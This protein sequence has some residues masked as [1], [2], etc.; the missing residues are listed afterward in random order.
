MLNGPLKVGHCNACQSD[1]P[2]PYE[3]W[4]N[5]FKDILEDIVTELKKG[6]GR[7][8]TIFG[9]F[10]TRLLYY[11]LPPRCS[12]CKK[13]LKIDFKK[14]TKPDEIKCHSCGEKIK[15]A[16]A[17]NWLQKKFPAA[18]SF[19]NAMLSEE[20]R[21]E[22]T[23]TE[24][25]ALTCTRCGGSLIVNGEDRIT[26]CEYCGIH[27]YLPDDLWLRLHPVLIKAEWY[28]IYDPKEVKKMKFD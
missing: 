11:R 25:V 27:V 19:V 7:N 2:I 6:E 8:S 5:I 26:P 16:P 15:V 4:T 18:H 12:N 9:H 10:N 21:P 20:D 28:I 1:T 13:S 14:I 22:S 23:I 3:F 24:G 17:P